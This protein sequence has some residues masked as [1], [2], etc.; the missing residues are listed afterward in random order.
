MTKTVSDHLS[1]STSLLSDVT[2]LK[3]SWIVTV[4]QKYV[5]FCVRIL[6]HIASHKYIAKKL[7]FSVAMLTR[8]HLTNTGTNGRSCPFS[9]F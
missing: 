7:T 6:D 2:G 4:I 5:I 3:G 1:N 8:S 9:K